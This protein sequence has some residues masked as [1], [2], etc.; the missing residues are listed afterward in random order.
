MPHRQPGRLALDHLGDRVFLFDADHADAPDDIAGGVA[1]QVAGGRVEN[2]IAPLLDHELVAHRD[3][4][5][6]PA[7][8]QDLPPLS[9][10]RHARPPRP[11]DHLAG[12]ATDRLVDDLGGGASQRGSVEGTASQGDVLVGCLHRDVLGPDG[13]FE[14][15]GG[16]DLAAFHIDHVERHAHHGATALAEQPEVAAQPQPAVVAGHVAEVG[17]RALD[18]V[19]HVLPS[20]HLRPALPSGGAAVLE[21]HL[22]DEGVHLA[23]F[24]HMVA[25]GG[26]ETIHEDV[27]H[28]VP[29]VPLQREWGVVLE[30]HHGDGGFDVP[31]GHGQRVAPGAPDGKDGHRGQGDTPNPSL[32]CRTTVH[33]R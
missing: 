4:P 13:F 19:L 11:G 28:P 31:F 9:D 24:Q 29:E 10:H 14:S 3:L 6:G 27:P 7:V 8:E 26:A 5:I 33:C 20:T 17:H 30:L 25:F 23:A 32:L 12:D 2:R 18:E 22:G 16:D 1:Q 15:L 21:A